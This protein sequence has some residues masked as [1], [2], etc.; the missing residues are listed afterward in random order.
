MGI[1]PTHQKRP[2]PCASLRLVLQLP[3]ESNSKLKRSTDKLLLKLHRKLHL[4]RNPPHPDILRQ[5]IRRNTA[6]IPLI[7]ADLHQLPQKFRPQP[8]VQV[9]GMEIAQINAFLR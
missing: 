3:P 2:L 8:L 6:D 9:Q 7:P 5:H 1:S 4:L